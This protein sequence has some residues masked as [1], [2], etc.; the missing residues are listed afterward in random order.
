MKYSTPSK[1][2]SLLATPASKKTSLKTTTIGVQPQ[3]YT[4]GE[5]RR[6]LKTLSSST[7]WTALRSSVAVLVECL[8][9]IAEVVIWGD[10]H[11]T[12]IFT[13][14]RQE[15]GLQR[16]A[17]L[18]K[19]KSNRQGPVA[20]Q[21]LQTFAMLVQNIREKSSLMYL[22]NHE[23]TRHT[24][25]T[26]FDFEDEEVLGYYVSFVR[27]ISFKM[28]ESTVTS[29]TRRVSQKNDVLCMPLFSEAAKFVNSSERMVRS[30]AR[31]LTLTIM[32]LK[33]DTVNAFLVSDVN[34]DF[35]KS[36]VDDLHR[37]GEQT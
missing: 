36:Q 17:H 24:I 10:Q 35:F 22:L 26:D 31:T 12:S 19:K 4:P 6:L 29:F 14:F 7:R 34:R 18:L 25:S 15:D 32:G 21:L 13:V 11:D 28:N 16:L 3:G 20:V 5:L 2:Q 33:N 30:A 1:K 9:R 23:A 27:S 8:R 37:K